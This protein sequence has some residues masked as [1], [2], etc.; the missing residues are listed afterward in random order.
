MAQNLPIRFQE[1]LQV[2]ALPVYPKISH[3]FTEHYTIRKIC[4]NLQQY[5][6]YLNVY[7][8]MRMGM[9]VASICIFKNFFSLSL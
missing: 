1:H 9:L 5:T 8:C 3:S 7:T 2:R 6:F 4:H